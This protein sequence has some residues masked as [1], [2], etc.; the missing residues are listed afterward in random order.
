M[1]DYSKMSRCEA[2][3]R[4]IGLEREVKRMAEA[5]ER[6]AGLVEALERIANP[7]SFMMSKLQDGEKL[8][9]VAALNLSTDSEYLKDIARAALAHQCKGGVE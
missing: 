7:I 2:V 9:G 4:C 6:I 5:R 3:E 1:T 8:N